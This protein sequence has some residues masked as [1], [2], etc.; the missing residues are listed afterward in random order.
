MQSAFNC[1]LPRS[2]VTHLAYVLSV[3]NLRGSKLKEQTWW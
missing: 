1:N 3:I 2:K